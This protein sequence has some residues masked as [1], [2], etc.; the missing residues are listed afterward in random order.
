MTLMLQI[1]C[2]K[3]GHEMQL[4]HNW[5]GAD[6]ICICG[7]PFD[8]HSGSGRPRPGQIG[9]PRLGRALHAHEI[10]G[11]RTTGP[12]LDPSTRSGQQWIALLIFGGFALAS[13]VLAMP[14]ADC[15]RAFSREGEVFGHI[16]WPAITTVTKFVLYF[17]VMSVAFSLTLIYLRDAKARFYLRWACLI[18]IVLMCLGA[19]VEILGHYFAKPDPLDLLTFVD[20]EIQMLEPKAPFGPSLKTALRVIIFQLLP[21]LIL[22]VWSWILD[23]QLPKQEDNSQPVGES[24]SAG[25]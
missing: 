24:P 20:G 17:S 14:D 2:A 16:L 11:N 6:M 25:G 22:I 1:T 9:N 3:C 8:A 5:T 15:S 4:P 12:K 13:I 23:K 18:L 7:K 10:A 19:V 21:A